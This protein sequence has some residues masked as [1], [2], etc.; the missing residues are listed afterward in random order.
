MQK[1]NSQSSLREAILLLEEKQREQGQLFK[2]EIHL[3]YESIQPINIIKKTFKEVFVTLDM[4]EDILNT[5]MSWTMG[6][7]SKRLFESVSDSPFKKLLGNI[8][9][10]G[11]TNVVERNPE[12]FR[13]LGANIISVI[14]NKMK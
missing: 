12:F 14:K 13:T 1:I 11:I 9:M 6:L 7:L 4:K 2:A 8:L 3:A 10:F 5:S